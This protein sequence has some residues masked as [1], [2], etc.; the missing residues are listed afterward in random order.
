MN[1]SAA[2]SC[3]GD[4]ADPMAAFGAK[5]GRPMLVMVYGSAADAK[6]FVDPTSPDE[7][8]AIGAKAFQLVQVNAEKLPEA[9]EIAGALAGKSTPRFV[10]FNADGKKVA[11][12]EGKISPGKL[13]EGMKAA[14][15]SSLEGFVKDYQKFLTAVD[16]L[17]GDKATLKVKLDRLGS[18]AE[19]DASVAAKQKEIDATSEKLVGTEKKLL[20]K[21]S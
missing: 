20:Q 3:D 12:V 11:T 17:E 13:F 9:G 18:R 5:T 8:V 6:V 7:R 19:K 14:A 15:G 2:D 4:A 21:I 16:K 10:F 1:W